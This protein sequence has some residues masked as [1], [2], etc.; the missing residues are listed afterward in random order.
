VRILYAGNFE[1]PSQQA[2]AIQTIHTGHALSR[3]GASVRLIT[4]RP[5]GT[6]IAPEEALRLY[7]LEPH[8]RFTFSSVPV[9]RIGDALSFIEI[10][11]RLATTNVSYCLGAAASLLTGGK[12]KRPD[13]IFTRDPR[14]AWTFIKLRSLTGVRVVYEVHELFGTRPRDNRS[15]DQS[16]QRGVAD[17]TRSLEKFV[18]QQSDRLITLTEACRKLIQEVHQVPEPRIRTIPDGTRPIPVE[19]A[20]LR[21][22]RSVAYVGQLYRWKGVDTLIN[23]FSKVPEATLSIVGSGEMRDGRDVDRDRLERLTLE[24]GITDRITFHDFVPYEDVPRYLASAEVAVV[25]L[26]DVLMSRYFTS[27]LKLFDA[28]AAGTALVASDLDSIREVLRDGE[29]AVLVEPDSSDALAAGIR[30]LLD[31]PA[32]AERLA[33]TARSEVEQYTWER[34]A[35][36]ILEFLSEPAD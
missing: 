1:W 16:E 24:L 35:E 19:P 34:R 28:M 4:A 20:S 7:G 21:N 33:C 2:R 30:Q 6:P 12:A 31:D 22:R 26:P 9:L 15:L 10:H 32:Q 8:P 27:P 3:A 36:R 18:I 25:P 13:W 11:K 23:A 29:N 5:T 14:V 17:R